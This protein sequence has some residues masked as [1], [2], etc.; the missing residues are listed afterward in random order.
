MD[1]F[2]TSTLQKHMFRELKLSDTDVKNPGILRWNGLIRRYA[3]T[4]TT[5]TA[6]KKKTED[7]EEEDEDHWT[8]APTT[9]RGIPT[10]ENP[11]IF[12][13]Y[14]R[15]CIAAKSYQ[16][17]ICKFYL[18]RAY[19]YYPNNP[20]VCLCLAVAS[21]GRAMQRQSDDRHH[22]VVQAMAFMSQYR[23]LRGA[24]TAGVERWSIIMGERFIGPCCISVG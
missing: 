3:S 19:D 10:K 8:P 20:I 16:S 22:A 14:G 24:T 11:A 12:A 17:A 5:G 15:I 4:A 6:V 9:G 18:L 13:I 21:I 23:K 2:I 7:G 1:S